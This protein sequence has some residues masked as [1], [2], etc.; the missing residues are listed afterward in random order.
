[1]LPDEPLPDDVAPPEDPLEPLSPELVDP[2]LVSPPDE[3][4]AS[5]VVDVATAPVPSPL[6]PQK[7][8]AVHGNPSQQLG[9]SGEHHWVESASGTQLS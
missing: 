5:V 1:M 3:L 9:K 2:E 8:S 7:P 4:V 6:P